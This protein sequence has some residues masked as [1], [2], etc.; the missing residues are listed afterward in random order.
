M[1]KTKKY[2]YS[3]LLFIIFISLTLS[4]VENVNFTNYEVISTFRNTRDS[5]DQP[6][7]DISTFNP[8]STSFI[9]IAALTSTKF[10]V[11]YRDSGNS[12]KGTAVIGETI[13]NNISWGNE[14]VF[15]NANTYYISVA[16]FSDTRFVITYNDYGGGNDGTAIIGEIT[17]TEILFGNESDFRNSVSYNS[18]AVLNDSTIVVA[19][20]ETDVSASGSV[21]IGSV[22][23]NSITSWVA[24]AQFY[25]NNIHYIDI[26]ALNSTK[27]VIVYSM[28]NASDHLGKA[29][30]GT[31]N[32]STITLG[33]ETLMNNSVSNNCSVSAFSDS[34]FIVAYRDEGNSDKGT[35]RVGNVN[36]TAINW[37]A[38]NIFHTASTSQTD[39]AVLSDTLFTVTYSDS[40]DQT[41]KCKTGRLSGTSIDWYDETKFTTSDP[42][43]NTIL[44]LSSTGFVVAYR[45]SD[46]SDYGKAVKG[47][48]DM[49]YI[50]SIATQDTNGVLAGTNDV[51]VIGIEVNTP[52]QLNPFSVTEFIC[53]SNG[54]T[55]ANEISNATLYYTGTDSTFS[56]SNQ[57]GS[58]VSNPDG[59]FSFTDS[60]QL[61]FGTNYFWLTYDVSVDALT[62]NFIDAECTQITVNDSLRIPTVTAP[63]GAREII[64]PDDFPGTALDFDG[65]DDYVNIGNDSSLNVG[66]TLTIEGW[67]KPNDLSGRQVIY[68]TRLNNQ[69]GSFQLEVGPGNG[70]TNRVAVTGP[71]IWVAET[72]DYALAA[73]EWSHIVY[74]RSG[75]GTT[76]KIYVN[77]EEQT[78]VTNADY[79]F[80]NNN[81]DKLIGS[82]NEVTGFFNGLSDEI[83]LWD[84]IR[85]KYEIREN[86]YL[87]LTSLEDGLAAYWQFNEASGT[88]AADHIHLNTGTLF[89]MTEDDWV[90]SDIPFAGGVSNT[91]TEVSGTVDFAPADLVMD[92]VSHNSASVTVTKL[93]ASPNIN[94]VA[95]DIIFDDQYWVVNRFGIG[96]FEAIL[97][98]AVNEDFVER[99]ESYPHLI[100]LYTRSSNAETD[101]VYLADAFSADAA[102]DEVTFTGI[103]GFGQFII[104][105]ELPEIDS[106]AGSC[107]VF[108]GVDSTIN[109]GNNSS[110]DI[111][112]EMT[113]ET[114]VKVD[115]F[116]HNNRIAVKGNIEILFWDAIYE[117]SVGKGCQVRLP[118]T[119]NTNYI[120][121][122]HDF[123]FDEWYHVS[124]TYSSSAS[125][126]KMYVNGALDKEVSM[127]GSITT[128]AD[129]LM[130]SDAYSGLRFMG[131]M[132]EVRLW[133]TAR[134]AEQIRE[135][136]HLPLT[137]VET[138]LVSYWQFNEGSGD[139]TV[140]N[141]SG[142]D[143]AMDYMDHNA[144]IDSTIPFGPGFADSQLVNNP[145]FYDFTD[146]NFRM[147]L[148]NAV[149]NEPIT[150][151]K[152]ETN[153]NMNPL[154]VDYVFDDQYWAINSFGDEAY[155]C[156][157]TFSNIEGIAESDV[158]NPA[159]I[160]LY[161]RDGN[162][163]EDWTLTDSSIN[164]QITGVLNEVIF[165][166]V[167]HFSQ[168]ILSRK[169]GQVDAPQNVAISITGS[170]VE[171]SWGAVGY[172]NSYKV[173]SSDNPYSGF[174]EDTSGTF[175]GES[176][177]APAP[178]GKMFYY[179]T[180][181]TDTVRGG[182][183][184]LYKPASRD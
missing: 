135:N 53:N 171:I 106:F 84:S 112:D 42:V 178:T 81:S 50:T 163:D 179:V 23:G 169:V 184:S 28:Q 70:G 133:N 132:D 55:N 85:S 61:D 151:T 24:E 21:R 25:N 128:N 54:T 127:T 15:N 103:T 20:N 152:L 173:F 95:P 41:G 168:F 142:N 156:D 73:G 124:W 121:F 6:Y 46:D 62:G 136:M 40:D 3:V 43:F 123:E 56:L 90:D 162:S 36:G 11:V 108:N 138:G 146:T 116:A 110:L 170:N 77:G 91:Q 161:S 72:N 166:N 174:L 37:N 51:P 144:W 160:K 17:G 105:K 125:S 64:V 79:T 31:I 102:N 120:E 27:F 107:L 134:T 33:N 8:A 2:M 80:M 69:A 34:L 29:I 180:A 175:T 153:P 140:D 32:G 38:A 118:G 59:S 76:H 126:L 113:F 16:I 26:T 119:S 83:R 176:W 141:V 52:G 92:F 182:N 65:T 66:N 5:N 150:V 154:D 109:C 100:K 148:N 63:A 165:E 18:V 14:Y 139:E 130:I 114:W 94:P 7:G 101:W 172:A 111:S 4:A 167:D 1:S 49:I 104:A 13:G 60:Q 157:L 164:V 10:V 86:M 147:T 115:S 155:N 45:D 35:V 87:P 74:T 47:Y 39:V 159:F 149:T 82:K 99:D 88:T 89:N 93:D 97:T 22:V 143:G 98:F 181:S 48:I 122:D 131:C 30:I 57:F 96:T 183:S 58:V 75:K 67:I 117:S 19:Y 71:G 68:S 44:T 78:L 145:G 9:D 158:N 12:G 129:D 177:S 137:G